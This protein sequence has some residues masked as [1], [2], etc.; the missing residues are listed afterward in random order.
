MLICWII[1]RGK[2]NCIS[3][4]KTDYYIE[5]KKRKKVKKKSSEMSTLNSHFIP[6]INNFLPSVKNFKKLKKNNL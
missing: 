4:S 2:K 5:I 1:I 3:E 6:I